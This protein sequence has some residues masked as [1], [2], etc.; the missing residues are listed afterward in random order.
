[1]N[2]PSSSSISSLPDDPTVAVAGPREADSHVLLAALPELATA[3]VGS[4]AVDGLWLFDTALAALSAALLMQRSGAHAVAVHLGECYA[5]ADGPRPIDSV[6]ALLRALAGSA[7]PGQI[8]ISEASFEALAD[9]LPNDAAWVSTLSWRAHGRYLLDGQ[10]EAVAVIEVLSDRSAGPSQPSESSGLHRLAD[11]GLIPGWRAAVGQEVPLR[12]GWRLLQRLGVGGFGEAWLGSHVESGE[13]RVFKFCYHETRLVSLKREVALF[14]MLQKGVDGHPGILPLL[15]WHLDS[16]PYFLESPHIAGGDLRQWCAGRGGVQAVPLADRLEIAA[17]MAEAL[18]AAHAVG[19]LHKDIKPT[20]VLMQEHDGQL[21]VTLADFGVGAITE[22]LRGE[23][24]QMTI[25]GGGSRS[26][27]FGDSALL[28]GTPKYMAPE[29]FEG[30][31]STIHADVFAFGVV[32]YQ[33][34]VGDLN[35][36]LG[37]TWQEEVGSAPLRAN[38]A[39]LTARD[40]AHRRTDL[41]V[42]AGELRRL[43]QREAELLEAQ[44]AAAAAARAQRRRRL[45]VPAVIAL[46]LLA[47]VLAGMLQRISQEAERANAEAAR[48]NAEATRANL[49]A[50]RANRE[51]TTASEVT[52]FFV[53]LFKIANPDESRGAAVTVREVLDTGAERVDEELAGQPRVRARLLLVISNVYRQL[54][55]FVAAVPMAERA[56]AVLRAEGDTGVDLARTLNALAALHGDAGRFEQ[57][58]ALAEESLA[59]MEAAGLQDDVHYGDALSILGSVFNDMGERERAGPV[60]ER[61]VAWR[62]QHLPAG[63]PGIAIALNNYGFHRLQLGDYRGSAELFERSLAI[64]RASL[65]EEHSE[66]AISWS[67]LSAVYRNRGE[68]DRADEAARRAAAI[69]E[70]TLGLNHPFT[71]VGWHNQSVLARLRGKQQEARDLSNRALAVRRAVH[72]E[73]HP[74]VASSLSEVAQADSALGNHAEAESA[75]RS[76]LALRIKRSGADS[77][78]VALSRITLSDI[79]L[80]AGSNADA[81]AEASAGAAQLRQLAEAAPEDRVLRQEFAGG[82]FQWG[83]S[84]ARNGDRDAAIPIWREA[85]KTLQGVEGE[86]RL[87]RVI[88]LRAR[89]H[90]ALGEQES[91]LRLRK[92]LDTVGF[93]D[94]LLDALEGD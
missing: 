88:Q 14:R 51:A 59:L 67:N 56:V 83:W 13:R 31:P 3:P 48:A 94:P 34:A 63:D 91:S 49:E 27:L 87:I 12:R 93:V 18:A 16:P 80:A 74:W 36:A 65:G 58:V 32:L 40:P 45:L 9:D 69:W 89:L 86:D 70:A 7:A 57:S 11:E 17:Q 79:L 77:K 30:R 10:G 54:G 19:V 52:E 21:Q 66:T 84:L 68:L 81:L 82:L 39:S 47:L 92:E 23:A 41:A 42:L 2:G 78:D 43:N 62:E 50:Q 8:L 35:R 61:T 37:A 75:Q 20:N 33:L 60:L 22:A 71:T 5:T 6:S 76:V 29:L 28:G 44:R 72:G 1:M 26:A 55:L 15:D 53:D 46:L 24:A 25:A 4:R 64:R 85:L 90:A 38:I 73:D